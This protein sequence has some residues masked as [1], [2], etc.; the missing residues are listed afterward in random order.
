MNSKTSLLLSLPAALLCGAAALISKPAA[1]QGTGLS[2]AVVDFDLAVK[3]YPRTEGMMADQTRRQQAY[4]SQIT[5]Q[6]NKIQEMKDERDGFRV[7]SPEYVDRD[8]RVQVEIDYIQRMSRRLQGTMNKETGEIFLS[9]YSDV[10]QA[11]DDW[12][13][14]NEIDLVLRRWPMDRLDT[15]D[16]IQMLGNAF[17]S[18]DTIY[19]AP[20][21]DRTVQVSDFLRTW[22]PSPAASTG[23]TGKDSQPASTGK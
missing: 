2:I 7:G 23:S 22:K 5:A 6:E 11:I 3:A 16:D 18:F 4:Q 17:Q 12:A 1:P 8:E 13:Q 21:L 19:N 14:Q 15:V 9:L 10:N 20:G